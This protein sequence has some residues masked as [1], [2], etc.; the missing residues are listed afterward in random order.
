MVEKSPLHDLAERA[1]A[2]WNEEAGRLTAVH[3]G[4]AA[5]EYWHACK[6]A[7]LFDVSPHAKV[8]LT[9][10]EAALFLHNLCTNDIRNLPPQAGCE[11]FFTNAKARIEAHAFIYHVLPTGQPESWWLS[12]APGLSGNLIKHLDHF[13]I[14][15]QVE[16]SDRTRDLAQLHLA[17][18]QAHALLAGVLP[19]DN[20]SHLKPEGVCLPSRLPGVVQVRRHQPLGLTGFDLLC[21]PTQAADVWQR[22]LKEGARPA[23]TSCWETLRVEAGTPVPGIDFDSTHL[24]M[25][26]GRI[27]QTI[28]YTKGCFLGQEPI[29]RA[30]DIGHVNRTLLGVT[31][32][33]QE[34]AP[35]GARLLRGAEEVG[36]V[37]S[38]VWSPRLGAAIALA[39]VRR[40]H[41]EPGTR[42][43]IETTGGRHGGTV[44]ALPVVALE[45]EAD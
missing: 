25:E 41:Q 1:G 6:T 5:D 24:V 18:P 42:L 36:E 20:L 15:E 23:G 43:E 39:Y 34:P 22:L 2:V 37:T 38:S 45:A 8:E 10:P 44:C 40:G 33:C 4:N 31:L 28:C 7:A 13:R 9:G 19:G 26:V 3:F 27:K 17:G 16:F 29:V 21:L 30:R 12:V 11:A 32:E 14:S 35:P